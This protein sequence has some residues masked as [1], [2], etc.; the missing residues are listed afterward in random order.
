MADDKKAAASSSDSSDDENKTS[1]GAVTPTKETATP[2]SPPKPAAQQHPR[3]QCVNWGNPDSE[4][5][6]LMTAAPPLP[7]SYGGQPAHEPRALTQTLYDAL[8]AAYTAKHPNVVY[9]Q[10]KVKVPK[11]LPRP[12]RATV[13]MHKRQLEAAFI[14]QLGSEYTGR[15]A[16]RQRTWADYKIYWAKHATLPLAEYL[17]EDPDTKKGDYTPPAPLPYQPEH[18]MTVTYLTVNI[19]YNGTTFCIGC[20]HATYRFDVHYWCMR[21]T[22]LAGYWPCTADKRHAACTLCKR[23]TSTARTAA[24]KLWHRLYKDGTLQ[25]AEILKFTDRLPAYIGTHF[26]ANVVQVILARNRGEDDVQPLDASA[27]QEAAIAKSYNQKMGP[28]TQPDYD[29]GEGTSTGKRRGSKR[30]SR[31]PARLDPSTVSVESLRQALAASRAQTRAAGDSQTQ[32]EGDCGGHDGDSDDGAPAKR[33]HVSPEDYDALHLP[34]NYIAKVLRG[35]LGMNHATYRDETGTRR[36]YQPSHATPTDVY[37]E[38]RLLWKG[39]LH[40]QVAYPDQADPPGSWCLIL[41]EADEVGACDTPLLPCPAKE[42]PFDVPPRRLTF[43]PPARYHTI[44]DAQTIQW[45]AILDC[46]LA[47][48]YVPTFRQLDNPDSWA[49]VYIAPPGSPSFID[50]PRRS[51]VLPTDDRTYNWEDISKFTREGLLELIKATTNVENAALTCRAFTFEWWMQCAAPGRLVCDLNYNHIDVTSPLLPPYAS[52]DDPTIHRNAIR[53]IV[54]DA[55]D[56]PRVAQAFGG[57]SVTAKAYMQARHEEQVEL[58]PTAPHGQFLQA[59]YRSRRMRVPVADYYGRSDAAFPVSSLPPP[60]ASAWDLRLATPIDGFT[61]YP[62]C[63]LTMRYI[64]EQARVHLYQTSHREHA[65]HFIDRDLHDL[66]EIVQ[67]VTPAYRRQARRIITNT[68]GRLWHLL[69][70]DVALTADMIMTIVHARRQGFLSLRTGRMTALDIQEA[71]RQPIMNVDNLL[72]PP[73]PPAP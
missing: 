60:N 32:Q 56:V 33:V 71:L 25:H 37:A 29:P 16:C 9:H 3:E 50:V 69:L 54:P 6:Y 51:V 61:S 21:C 8:Q 30:T 43:Q 18:A 42:E 27:V 4:L 14:K 59:L 10:L 49:P 35:L 28:A 55:P 15:S 47:A 45:P 72:T 2:P 66:Y 52:H 12:M 57:L 17:G 67:L 36:G 5:V 64:E 65:L 39:K 34:W 58:I 48:T 53:P 46:R 26:D 7:S 1:T 44:M 11:N 38:M 62:V 63:D 40:V 70:D 31:P 24:T 23:L 13:T 73:A 20:R 41:C 19:E 22:L 68:L